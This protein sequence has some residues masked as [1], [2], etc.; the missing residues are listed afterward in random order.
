MMRRVK[1]RPV[2]E[3]A[4]EIGCRSW[5]QVFLNW[6][7]AHPAVTCVIPASRDANHVADNMGAGGDPLPDQ[8]MRRRMAEY[9][10]SL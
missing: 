9:F 10:H 1:G 7:V 6:I 4:A 3:W 5:A 2:P 8:A